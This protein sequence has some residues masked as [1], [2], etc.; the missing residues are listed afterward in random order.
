MSR[1]VNRLNS[2]LVLQSIHENSRNKNIAPML[3]PHTIEVNKD[4]VVKFYKH[5][6]W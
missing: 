1:C 2:V 5:W 6:R 4:Y 3:V